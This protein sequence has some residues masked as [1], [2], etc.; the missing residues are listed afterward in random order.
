[1]TK[2]AKRKQRKQAL[3]DI[4]ESA[5]FWLPVFNQEA[6]NCVDSNCNYANPW[7]PVEFAR[8]ILDLA[9]YALDGEVDEVGNCKE[10][11]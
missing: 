3:Q 11:A 4:A 5:Q 7:L 6:M 9:N 10:R 2:K 1:M 8:R